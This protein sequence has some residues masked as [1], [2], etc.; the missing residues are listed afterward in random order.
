[1]TATTT[2]TGVVAGAATGVAAGVTKG[3]KGCQGS[4]THIGN[5]CQDINA[6]ESHW[7]DDDIN[8][9][10][11]GGGGVRGAEY[12]ERTQYQQHHNGRTPQ[13]NRHNGVS[14]HHLNPHYQKKS[15]DNEQVFRLVPPDGGWGW[16]VA[17]GT[18]IITVSPP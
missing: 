1:M 11:G 10:G 8:S 17:L 4:N 3:G 14:P 18:F 12:G 5:K 6:N 15:L 13:H 9:G 16:M 7:Y 2:E